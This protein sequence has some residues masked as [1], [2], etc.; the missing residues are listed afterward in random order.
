MVLLH[1]LSF[2]LVNI[3]SPRN[4]KHEYSPWLQRCA[5]FPLSNSNYQIP[6]DKKYKFFHPH[7]PINFRPYGVLL[8]KSK[9]STVIL[10]AWGEV[11]STDEKVLARQKVDRRE[12]LASR[13]SAAASQIFVVIIISHRT[14]KLS[15]SNWPLSSHGLLASV[16]CCVKNGCNEIIWSSFILPIHYENKKNSILFFQIILLSKKRLMVFFDYKCLN[17]ILRVSEN[18][19]PQG[20]TWNKEEKFFHWIEVHVKY[21]FNNES[22][23]NKLLKTSC[24][25]ATKWFTWKSRGNENKYSCKYN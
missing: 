9:T 16:N 12:S 17:L 11:W 13:N 21:I 5:S 6:F 3:S 1:C 25:L 2:Q 20:K 19:F 14:D 8:Q 7:V 15:S 18:V 23:E 10:R 22:K 24:L 4:S